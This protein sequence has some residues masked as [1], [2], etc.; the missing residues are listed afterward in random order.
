ME[1]KPRPFCGGTAKYELAYG[2]RCLSC[3][4]H[5][6]C[7]GYDY[8]PWNRRADMPI[9]VKPLAWAER[10]EGLWRADD[11]TGGCYEVI[12]LSES[13]AACHH[14]VRGYGVNIGSTHQSVDDAKT[15]SQGHYTLR[16]LAALDLAPTADT[17]G[18]YM[19]SQK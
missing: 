7:S 16:I 15:A 6:P 18:G 2:I 9:W 1:I 4:A 3:A 12:E 13:R 11:P 17:L 10:T 14:V 19:G 8:G 5:A